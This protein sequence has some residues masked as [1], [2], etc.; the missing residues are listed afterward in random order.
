VRDIPQPQEF[1]D[2]DVSWSIVWFPD[3]T[4]FLAVA[5][6]A[7]K[8]ASTWQASVLGGVLREVRGDAV[9]WSVSPDGSSIALTNGGRPYG[10]EILSMGADGQNP[11]KLFEA[12]RQIVF[13]H[14]QWSPD[15]RRLLYLKHRQ[16]PGHVGID[17]ESRDLTGGPPATVFS[18]PK[19]REL[20][21]L[22]DGRLLYV[23]SEPDLNRST[24]THWIAK[25]D[26]ATG[27]LSGQPKELKIG[28]GFCMGAI[29]ATSNGRRS[30]FTKRTVD[31]SVLV[32]AISADG[33]RISPPRRLTYIDAQEWPIGW[34]VDSR[35]VI[36]A[37]NRGHA[38]GFYKQR[39]DSDDAEPVLQ[40]IVSRGLGALF[41]AVSPDGA[42]LLYTPYPGDHVP[43]EPIEVLRVPMTG[44]KPALVLKAP[45]SDVLRCAQLPARLCAVGTAE[46]NQLVF[47]SFDPVNG[48]G[49][50]LAR[51]DID[52]NFSYT[53]NLSSDGSRIGIVK[54]GTGE[55]RIVSLKTRKERKFYAKQWDH[56]F[57]MDWTSDGTGLLVAAA[58]PKS[59]LLHLDL[60]GN[61]HVIW[62]PGGNSPTYALASPDGSHLALLSYAIRSNVWMMENF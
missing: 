5:Y 23:L 29:S 13:S 6:S 33:N 49:R 16:I 56:L 61:G 44:G 32:A 36:F 58:R 12:P 35:S 62:E 48:I 3:S 21:W 27:A 26:K 60:D 50:E 39:L 30:T 20:H 9:A 45:L 42:W 10:S 40:G 53:W 25:T 22:P 17:V 18:D 2:V 28:S 4:R 14:V 31:I 34:T 11:R 59:A 55:I 41:G 47:T 38:W 1:K 15:G 19:L 52:P 7:G 8:P 37:S 43:G 51:V 24:C 54:R 57:G 46:G